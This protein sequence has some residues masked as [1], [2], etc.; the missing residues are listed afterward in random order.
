MPTYQELTKNYTYSLEKGNA[1]N[2]LL[3]LSAL[4]RIADATEKMAQSYAQIIKAKEEAERMR[5][6]NWK[7][8]Q[9]MTAKAESLERS[10]RALRGVITR[11]K[12]EKSQNG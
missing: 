7:W 2:D 9:E 1:T 5:D 12:K 4:L 6:R 10:N 8:F 3:Q 11:M